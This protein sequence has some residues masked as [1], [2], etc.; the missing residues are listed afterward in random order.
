MTNHLDFK[1]ARRTAAQIAGEGLFFLCRSLLGRGIKADK[2]EAVEASTVCRVCTRGPRGLPRFALLQDFQT[3]RIKIDF[4]R[5]PASRRTTV[6]SRA[7]N[8]G[9]D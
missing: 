6:M 4:S 1:G 3:K 9:A 2:I 7:F 5:P 8:G